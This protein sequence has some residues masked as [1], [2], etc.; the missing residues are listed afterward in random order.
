MPH[1]ARTDFSKNMNIQQIFR[2]L[3][4]KMKWKTITP[5]C[6]NWHFF[7]NYMNIQH[8]LRISILNEQYIRGCD[9]ML[10]WLTKMDPLYR[11][12]N[13]LLTMI[14]RHYIHY[15]HVSRGNVT[16]KLTSGSREE[17]IEIV[18]IR[19]DIPLSDFFVEG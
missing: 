16:N 1:T 11:Y 4:H 9:H 18:D 14:H 5:H 17:I 7:F 10:K 13:L 6:Q 19:I 12:K 8:I 3:L 2:I 15:W